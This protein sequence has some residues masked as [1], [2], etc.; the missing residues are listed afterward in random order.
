MTSAR[1][2]QILSPPVSNCQRGE[3]MGKN[4]GK[5]G[6]YF[7]GNRVNRL[8]NSPFSPFFPHFFKNFI[9]FYRIFLRSIGCIFIDQY[10]RVEVK[11]QDIRL[12]TSV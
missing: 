7:M 8:G 10:F 5:W 11:E 4:G 2:W 1:F 6:I 9:Y 3:P 12:I